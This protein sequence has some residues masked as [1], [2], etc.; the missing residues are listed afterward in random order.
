MPDMRTFSQYTS[1]M[2]LARSVRERAIATSG[3]GR[4]A[5]SIGAETHCH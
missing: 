5:R 4:A 2:Q 3:A 1:D